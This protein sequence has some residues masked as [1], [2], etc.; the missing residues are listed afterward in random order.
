MYIYFKIAIILAALGG[1]ALSYYIYRKKRRKE[2]MVC[3]LNSDCD[4]VTSSAYAKFFGV[5][6]ELM[7]MIYYAVIAL[8]YGGLLMYPE[9]ISHEL[10]FG[11]LAISTLSALFSGY[12][13]SIQA[14]TLKEWCT[15]CLT[16]AALSVAIFL[17]T[18]FSSP[19]GITE[20]LEKY[21]LVFGLLYAFMLAL[22]VGGV[23]VSAVIFFRFLRDFR[24]SEFEA[25]TL[26][27]ISQYIWF[28]LGGITLTG[29]GIYLPDFTMLTS[30]AVFVTQVMALVVI[31]I[32]IGC[33]DFLIAP[34]LFKISL[35]EDHQHKMGELRSLRKGA[36][37][38]LVL[39]ALSW[40]TLYFLNAVGEVFSH[41]NLLVNAYGLI[42]VVGLVVALVCERLFNS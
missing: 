32:T 36:Y 17:L 3:P 5:P 41:L 31:L 22:G 38:C 28:T 20:L 29:I 40:Y 19:Y 15:W 8:A 7:G 39:G 11:L 42:L 27:V 18:P 12:L 6:L 30:N 21:V 13:T 2:N 35:G 33:V 9:Y 10:A 14:F 26:R 23:T 34:K 4:A 1:F 25:T 37:V 24:I 16:S